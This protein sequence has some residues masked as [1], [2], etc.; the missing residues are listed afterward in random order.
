MN[1]NLPSSI[2]VALIQQKIFLCSERVHK[3][4]LALVH[5][6]YRT[7]TVEQLLYQNCQLPRASSQNA[8]AVTD[9]QAPFT[10][11]QMF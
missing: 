11:H 10:T 1:A 5:D 3:G 2:T 9:Q 4:V 8:L 7:E 6:V